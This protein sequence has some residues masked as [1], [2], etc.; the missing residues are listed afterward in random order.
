[1]P[2][3]GKLLHKRLEAGELVSLT[4]VKV[5]RSD[6]F[7]ASLD[8]GK[9]AF[10]VHCDEDPVKALAYVLETDHHMR[11]KVTQAVLENGVYVTD[12]QKSRGLVVEKQRTQMTHD[13]ATKRI[14]PILGGLDLDELLS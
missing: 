2:D 5:P 11:R 14:E 12:V 1:M 8:Y 4:L 13:N 6:R 9:G 10:A 7:Q 3:L